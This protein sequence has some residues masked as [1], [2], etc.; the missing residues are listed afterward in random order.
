MLYDR[1][2]ELMY[3]GDFISG[4]YY[5]DKNVILKDIANDRIV[6][7]L[8]HEL[9]ID[10]GCGNDY[11]G[12]LLLCGFDYLERL[13]VKKDSFVNVN[14]LKIS[15]NPVLKSIETEDSEEESAGFFVV[16]YGCL[17]N[18]KSVIIESLIIDD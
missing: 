11:K 5:Y 2:G 10:E 3:E 7:S 8:I 4:S 6:H 14:S 1:K 9:V 15:D 16:L 17:K 18:V 13:V 12:D